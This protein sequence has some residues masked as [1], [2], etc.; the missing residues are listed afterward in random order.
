MKAFGV[1][2]GFRQFFAVKATPNPFILKIMKQE[3]FGLDC[4]SLAELEMAQ[5]IGFTYEDIFV[6]NIPGKR[7]PIKTSPTNIAGELEE[8]MT[9]ES[10]VILRKN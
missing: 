5:K 2:Q 6:R 7:M 9:K 1:L 3:G 4:S 10:I 8:T